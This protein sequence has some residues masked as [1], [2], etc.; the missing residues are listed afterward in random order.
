MYQI[1][2]DSNNSL[3]E[4]YEGLKQFTLQEAKGCTLTKSTHLEIEK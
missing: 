2:I 4:A 1:N 3:D